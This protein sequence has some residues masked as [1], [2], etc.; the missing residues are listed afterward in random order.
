DRLAAG[1]PDLPGWLASAAARAVGVLLRALGRAG[2]TVPGR[3]LLALDPS[4]LSRI[5]SRLG[6]GTILVSATN[7]KTTTAALAEAALTQSGLTVF[8]N[9]AGANMAGGIASALV[10]AEPGP[11]SLGLLEIDEFWLPELAPQLKP[12]AV[13]LGNLFRDQL[14][15]YGELD[16]ILNRWIEAALLLAADGTHFVL[17]ADDPGIAWLGLQLPP[18]SV[19]WFGVEDTTLA[20]KQLPHAADAG[21]CR[22]CSSPLN[23]SAVLLGHLGHWICPSCGLTRPTPSVAVV[24]ITLH[25]A[26]SSS[27]QIVSPTGTHSVELEVPG[28]Y[29]AYN[30]VGAWALATKVGVA[31][32]VVASAFGSAKASFGRAETFTFSEREATLFLVKNPTG[33]NEVIRALAAEPDPL[34]L[35]FLLNDGIADG[36][37]VSWIWD[38]DFEDIAAQIETVVCSGTRAAE[39]ALRFRYSGVP[40]DR[41]TVIGDPRDGL[42]QLATTRQESLWVLP[43]YTAML[44]LRSTLADE[45]LVERVV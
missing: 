3:V 13:L 15:R 12:K 28:V 10:H 20:L 6:A 8:H 41:I 25:G 9:A 33:A 7:G 18:A 16:A 5:S 21:S 39:A 23:Y 37:D 40:A 22:R 27:L 14:D 19:T 11:N 42:T 35:Q 4:A 1:R 32:N 45:G 26:R 17:C 2:T 34:A 43:T 38:A 31:S 30:A 24:E 44:D 36:R 29:N